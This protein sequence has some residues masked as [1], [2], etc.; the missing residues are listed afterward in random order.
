VI[1]K[2]IELDSCRIADSIKSC[3]NLN[4]IHSNVEPGMSSQITCVDNGSAEKS[5]KYGRQDGNPDLILDDQEFGWS[6][7]GPRKKNRK[8]IK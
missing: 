5:P 2:M 3:T 1:N 6:K 7:V 4:C 8:R